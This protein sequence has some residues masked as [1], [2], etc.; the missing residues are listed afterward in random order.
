[1]A[2]P[3]LIDAVAAAL[4][5]KGYRFARIDGE[6]VLRAAFRAHHGDIDLTVQTHDPLHAVAL[7]AEA[8]AHAPSRYRHA[9]AELLTRTNVQLTV[10]NFEMTWADG[11]VYFR[12]ANIFPPGAPEPAI[13]AGMVHAAV[14]E[15]DQL[16]GYLKAV[17]DTPQD[18]IASLDIARLLRRQD[19][20]PPVPE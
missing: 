13:L 2:D 4:R 6:D 11:R 10:G 20:L 16:T 7:V 18:Q 8:A 9:V 3:S 19:L 14:A 15:T 5:E 12:L 1:M 17:L